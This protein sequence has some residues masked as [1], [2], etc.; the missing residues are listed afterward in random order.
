MFKFKLT[1]KK[2]DWDGVCFDEEN[3][4]RECKYKKT[5]DS[6]YLVEFNNEKRECFK[7][8]EFIDRFIKVN[9]E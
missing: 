6:K 8:K 2:I 4:Q 3:M 1:K 5:T 7:E 9:R